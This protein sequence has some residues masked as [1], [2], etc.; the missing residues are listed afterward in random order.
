MSKPLSV[1]SVIDK[2]KIS[3]NAVWVA[4]LDINIVDPNTRN[5]TDSVHIAQNNED[6]TFSGTTYTAANFEM[7][8][9]QQQSQAPSV[10]ITVHDQLGIIAEKLENVAGGVFSDVSLTIVNT[11]RLNS[12]SE[13]TAEF[14]VLSTSIKDYVITFDLGAENP[15]SIAFPKHTQRQ[16][17]CAWRFKGYGC[18]YSGAY[19]VCDYTRNGPNGCAV[20]GNTA[21]FRAL[22]GLVRMNI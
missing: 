19:P 18:G 17:R 21:N 20:K 2:N 16:D 5:V 7:S 12:P 1:E 13:I 10:T 22:S 6:V 8:I 4:L 14:E 11:E 3:S 9:D 15:L